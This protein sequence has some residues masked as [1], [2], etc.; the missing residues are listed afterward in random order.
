MCGFPLYLPHLPGWQV[1]GLP[2]TSS[3]I[4][5]RTRA[6]AF[7]LGKLHQSIENH[8]KDEAKYLNLWLSKKTL[9]VGDMGKRMETCT[10]L[11]LDHNMFLSHPC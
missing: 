2:G 8:S 4:G 7:P 5:R 11:S 6:L 10:H 1:V 9:H 3:A